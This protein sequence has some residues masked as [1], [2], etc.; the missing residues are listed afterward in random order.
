MPPVGHSG[1]ILLLQLDGGDT[2]RTLTGVSNRERNEESS[3]QWSSVSSYEESIQTERDTE[4]FP[5]P[6]LP[7]PQ[8]LGFLG[9]RVTYTHV[10]CLF[11]TK[12]A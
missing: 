6:D 8:T 2:E 3:W 1:R 4:A 12:L 11:P 10:S 7:R 9:M 5:V